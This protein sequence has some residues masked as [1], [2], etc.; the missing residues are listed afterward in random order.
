[1]PA[2]WFQRDLVFRA[3]ADHHRR[4]ILQFLRMGP[5]SATYVLSPLPITRQA[6]LQHLNILEKAGLVTSQKR[7]RVR[8]CRL[9]TKRLKLAED[10]IAA[11]RKT[12]DRE[13][14]RADSR[15]LERRYTW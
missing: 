9:N 13:Y 2:Y 6:A 5:A 8:T 15:E 3:L 7:G 4:L 1:M 11:L 14:P 12:A 10:W